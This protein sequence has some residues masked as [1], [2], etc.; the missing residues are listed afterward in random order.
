MR[1]A[2]RRKERHDLV[3]VAWCGVVCLAVRC[4]R[5]DEGEEEVPSSTSIVLRGPR[6]TEAHEA[7]SVRL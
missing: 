4:W 2:G 5:R 3:G 1:V 7:T 6:T